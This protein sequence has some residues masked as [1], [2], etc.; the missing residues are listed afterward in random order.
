MASTVLIIDDEPDIRELLSMTISRMG[1][2]CHS[3]ANLQEASNLLSSYAFD[4]C[5]TDM[6]LPDGNGIEF[7]KHLKEHYPDLPVAVVT[8]HGDMDAAVVA[9]KNGAYD[10]V[11]K[12]VDIHQ[13]R[14]LVTT[15]VALGS[16]SANDSNIRA[17]AKA[18]SDNATD[19]THTN[20][21]TEAPATTQQHLAGTDQLIGSSPSIQHLKEM[22]LKL[23]RTNAPVWISGESGTGKELTARLIHENSARNKGPFV[24]INCGAIPANLMD[25]EFFGH[26][27]G[28]FTGAVSDNQGLFKHAEGGTLFLDEVAELTLPMQVKL[29]R[30]I[31]EKTIRPVGTADE[32]P[33]DVRILSASHKNL[34]DEVEAGRFRHDL[35][36]RLNVINLVCPSLRERKEDI[37]AL[38]NHMLAAIE[39][40]EINSTDG[41]ETNASGFSFTDAAMGSLQ[42]YDFPGN[43]R[44]LENI[45][46]RTTAIASTGL[47]DTADLQIKSLSLQDKVET[48]TE[49]TDPSNS[50]SSNHQTESEKPIRSFNAVNASQDNDSDP[51]KSAERAQIKAALNAHRWNRKATAKALGLT[52][53]QLRY[54]IEQLDLNED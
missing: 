7:V 36:Y 53:R 50:A 8:A 21:N 25:S 14:K 12:P 49:L 52:Y 13:L 20:Q 40:P 27:K 16:R 47:I 32:L 15:A 34:S 1:L 24:A 10:F 31:Q 33:T 30:A 6:R 17:E 37:P 2:D 28:S 45:L 23:G 43:V 26:K 29:L 9:M 38:V 54:R 11:S 4:A 41:D 48:A 46:E 44:E 19:S 3:A 39:H 42:S 51:T 5:L 35:Y 18:E 22:I